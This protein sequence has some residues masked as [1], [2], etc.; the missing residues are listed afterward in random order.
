[1]YMYIWQY[2]A[3][4]NTNCK[5]GLPVLRVSSFPHFLHLQSTSKDVIFSHVALGGRVL[6]LCIVIG[7]Q[8]WSV[9]LGVRLSKLVFLG[10]HLLR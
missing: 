8:G 6:L 1:M 9:L 2:N 7:G 5:L 4:V 3:F 10:S